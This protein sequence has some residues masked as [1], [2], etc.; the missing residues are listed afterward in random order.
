[1][2]R[3]PTGREAAL[4]FAFEYGL[5][6]RLGLLVEP[7]PYTAI[8]PQQGRRATGPGDIEAT[9]SYLVLPETPTRPALTVSGEVKIP[10][11]RDAL[12][13]TGQT[14]YTGYLIASKHLMPP[15]DVHAHLG[16]TVIGKPAG[17]ALNNIVSFGVGAEY[18]VAPRYLLF[19]EVLGNSASAPDG[20]SAD[21]GISVGP[22]AEAAGGE[23]VGTLGA[24]RFLRP[25]ALASLGVSYDN[26]GAVLLRPGL[27]LWFR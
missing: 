12:I 25:G 11:A 27:T 22:V 26:N 15:L 14:D 23:L 5:T 21:A 13:G 24:G 9:L 4:P 16:Y 10:T 1:M 20:E 19:G 2:Q 17:A 3:S 18:A 7:V 6:D 8:R